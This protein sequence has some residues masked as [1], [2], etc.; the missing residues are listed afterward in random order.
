MTRTYED[1]AARLLRQA[2]DKHERRVANEP[3]EPFD[4][5][6]L[7]RILRLCRPRAEHVIVHDRLHTMVSIDAGQRKQTHRQSSRRRRRSRANNH[8]DSGLRHRNMP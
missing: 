3:F 2:A 8:D 6:H 7:L 5:L 1:R 4:P